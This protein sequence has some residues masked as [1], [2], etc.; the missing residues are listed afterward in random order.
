MK[1]N[2]E[3]KG[4]LTSLYSNLLSGNLAAFNDFLADDVTLQDPLSSPWGGSWSG[5]EN[6]IAALP[7][8]GQNMGLGGAVIHDILIDNNQGVSIVTLKQMNKNGEIQEASVLEYFKFNE[9]GK[10]IEI[11]PHFFDVNPMIEFM[12]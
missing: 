12:K 11:K 1:S 10:I 8:V 6:V 4:I 9:Q 2:Q 3:L 7:F 5:K